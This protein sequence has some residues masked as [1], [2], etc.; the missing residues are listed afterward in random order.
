[1]YT[2]SSTVNEVVHFLS[3][4][5]HGLF[6]S[7]KD[8][9]MIEFKERV[10]DPQNESSSIYWAAVLQDSLGPTDN[11]EAWMGRLKS[12]FQAFCLE[13]YGDSFGL[14]DLSH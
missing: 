12:K 5:H 9:P 13:T 3:G 6:P 14:R 4:M 11:D 7:L 1:M 8:G 2:H 10:L